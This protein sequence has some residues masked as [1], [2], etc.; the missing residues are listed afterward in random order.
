MSGSPQQTPRPS[1]GFKK[2]GSNL[3][4]NFVPSFSLVDFS[5]ESL[6]TNETQK[7]KLVLFKY[8]KA[9]STFKKKTAYFWCKQR[10][11]VL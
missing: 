6:Q 2:T 11:F 4:I 7:A 10:H 8:Y 1:S 3:T 9:S 5:G